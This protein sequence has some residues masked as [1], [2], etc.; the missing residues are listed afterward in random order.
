MC[1]LNPLFIN[2]SGFKIGI[3]CGF[4]FKI[5]HPSNVVK[6]KSIN[7]KGGH[8]WR[9]DEEEDKIVREKKKVMD[10]TRFEGLVAF[11]FIY[12]H[13]TMFWDLCSLHSKNGVISF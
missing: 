2:G 10:A 3:V 4:D 11:N 13:D 8:S 9:N 12:N 5:S 1:L 6:K 7:K